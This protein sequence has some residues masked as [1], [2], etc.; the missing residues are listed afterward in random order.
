[1]FLRIFRRQHLHHVHQHTVLGWTVWIALC[2]VAI[3]VACVLAIAGEWIQ[4]VS[5]VYADGSSQSQSSRTSSASRLLCVM[6]LSTLNSLLTFRQVFASWYTYGLAGF[7]WLYDA[8]HLGGGMAGLRRHRAQTA[9]AILTIIIGAF[10]C[11]AGTYVSIK[12]RVLS[13]WEWNLLI[14]L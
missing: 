7:F 1:V 10:I 13:L 14:L 5:H 3:A 8:Y 12:D 11:V 9:L 6:T 4:N 2:F